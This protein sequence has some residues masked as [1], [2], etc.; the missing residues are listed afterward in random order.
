MNAHDTPAETFHHLHRDG[1]LTL[2]NVW[3]A[4]SAR[5]IE[6]LG[7]AAIATTSAGVAWSHGCADGERLP[8]ARLLAT[9]TAI[10]RAVSVPVTVDIEG[11]YAD[12]PA[13]VASTVAAVI[14]A[15]AVGIN[16]EDGSAA[17]DML[18]AKIAAARQTAERCG[19]A[20][21]INARTDVVLRALAPAEAAVD[22]ILARATRYRDAGADGLFVPGLVERDA[23]AA[24]AAGTPLRL[25]VMAR[26]G[27]PK[28]VELAALGVRRLSAGSAFSETLYGQ[29]AAQAADF[30]ADGSIPAVA[31]GYGYTELNS[32]FATAD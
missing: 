19:V 12:D 1:L 21:F 27:L 5:L 31:E 32:M 13:G 22:A 6:A 8:V 2:A 15:G 10:C 11:G 17:P 3:D 20:L 7:A 29:L 26:P 9:V 14:D 4:G 30:F 25:N 16:I 28:R 18:C 23:I 24:V